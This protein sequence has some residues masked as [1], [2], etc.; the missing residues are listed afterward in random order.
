MR[1]RERGGILS[2]LVVLIFLVAFCG[3][4]FLL[5]HPLLRFAGGLCVVEDVLAKS[6]ALVVLSDDNFHAERS[7]RAAE[8]F[9]AGWAPRIV[10]SGRRLR[11]YATVAELM[12]HDLTERGIPKD[13]II[14]FP[15]N[16]ENTREEAQALLPLAVEHK[17]NRLII[18]TSNY[19]TRRARYIFQ[20]V[21]PA[22]IEVRIASAR[23]SDYDPD[24]WWESR[25][26]IKLF[27]SETVG[28]SVAMWELRHSSASSPGP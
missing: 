28:M 12:A 27:F 18:V 25:K 14:R 7:A 26:G 23:D 5:R 13:A 15:Q 21:F 9:R 2:K 1:N 17:W 3:L 19:H 11:P 20:H 24:N 10:A 16:G 4:L 22:A 8:L 6:D